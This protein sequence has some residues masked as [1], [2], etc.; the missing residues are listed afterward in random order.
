RAVGHAVQISL[1]PRPTT[2]EIVGVVGDVKQFGVDGT[3]T[4]DLYIALA[5]IPPSQVAP[6]AAR[7]YWIVRTEGP[8]SG[9]V[10][11]IPAAVHAVDP[12]VAASSVRPLDEILAASLGGR[13]ASVRLLEVFGQAAIVLVVLGVYCAAAFAANGRRH[14]MAVRS[15]FG[16]QNRDLVTLV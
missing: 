6:V 15:A 3:A 1:G 13:R 11:P 10:E 5:Q 12:D 9:L 8:P 16:A 4:A 2:L 14:E 7:M